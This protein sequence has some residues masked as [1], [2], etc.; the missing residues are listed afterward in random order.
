MPEI[1]DRVQFVDEQLRPNA[2]N[3]HHL[4]LHLTPNS[5]A[6]S[7]FDPARVNFSACC[8]Y[9]NISSQ[10]HLDTIFAKDNWLNA[11]YA[12]V[13]VMFS[14]SLFTFIPNVYFDERHVQSYLNFNLLEADA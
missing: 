7:I 13:K 4:Y 8:S 5:L 11:Q 2:M 14:N 6:Y 9:Q 10:T 12:L 3:Q 1:K